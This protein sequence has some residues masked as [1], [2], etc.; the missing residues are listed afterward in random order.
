[1]KFKVK[2][3][4]T[5]MLL[6]LSNQMLNF[7]NDFPVTSGSNDI[8]EMLLFGMVRYFVSLIFFIP[9]LILYNGLK[10]EV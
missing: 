9:L 8:G 7:Y 1:M 3:Y 5:I 2:W 4:E 6:W 10:K